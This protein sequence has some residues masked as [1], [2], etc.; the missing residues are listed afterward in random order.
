MTTKQQERVEKVLDNMKAMAQ[1]DLNPHKPARMAM[2]LWSASYAASGKGSMG[3][4]DSLSES[5]KKTCR[6]AVAEI[7]A[8]RAEEENAG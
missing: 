8:A 6:S 2:W 7:E 1:R 3:Y 4:W 5:A